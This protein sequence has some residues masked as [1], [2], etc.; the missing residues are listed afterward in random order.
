MIIL[1][2]TGDKLQIDTTSAA[3][4]DVDVNWI[5]VLAGVGTGGCT[6][7][8]I[9]SSAT[10]QDICAAPSGSNIRYIKEIS[11]RNKDASL[12]CDV[13]VVKDNGGTDFEK[14]KATL[15][16]GYTLTYEEGLGWFLYTTT[17]AKL[18]T[19]LMVLSDSSHVQGAAWGNV[20]NLQCA[21]VSGNTY[22]FEAMLHHQVN[23]TT[24]GAQFGVGGVAMT[25]MIANAFQGYTTSLTAGVLIESASITAVDTAVN[26]AVSIGTATTNLPVIMFGY[27]KPSASGTFSL[28]AQC[29][30]VASATMTIKKGSWMKVTQT[31]N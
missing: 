20:N 8:A 9:A 1:A 28:R 19:T 16:P 17:T 25:E 27:F 21:V 22:I 10:D 31:D 30:Q 24:T 23:A 18:N 15:A 3:T 12:S 7:T 2:D 5:D 14:H 26:V 29:E 13:T 4:L 11:I 6:T